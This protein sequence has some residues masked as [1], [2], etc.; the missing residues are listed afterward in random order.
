MK[1]ESFLALTYVAQLVGY[2]P[3][4]GTVT[5]LIPSQSPYLGC[6]FG[7]YR[8]HPRGNKSMFVSH[9]DVSIPLFIPPFPPLKVNKIF[10]F[11]KRRHKS[12]ERMLEGGLNN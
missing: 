7:S 11:K 12:K 2:I 8:A 6:R 10:F 1:E 9:I 4:K 5:G 3:A